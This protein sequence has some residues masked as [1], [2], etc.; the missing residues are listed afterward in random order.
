MIKRTIHTA[1]AIILTLCITSGTA[2]GKWF[3]SGTPTDLE[4]PQMR[5]LAIG[6]ENGLKTLDILDENHQSVG[7]LSLRQFAFSKTFTC[8]IVEGQL[9]FGVPDGM[10][11]D[12]NPH[13]KLVASFDW[14]ESTQ[15]V[16]LLFLPRSLNIDG[17]QSTADYTIQLID[18]S[19][20]S[21][22]LGHTQV[23]NLTSFNAIVRVEEHSATVAPWDRT[24]FS[25][26]EEST[27]VN[28]AQ[29]EV[30]YLED[31]TE[32][33]AYQARIRYLDRIRYIAFIYTDTKRERIAVR[34][35]KD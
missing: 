2:H 10:D 28:M 20:E 16:C 25:K 6:L 15:Q 12:G 29:F 34:I 4:S 27:G 24:Q 7:K 3:G 23:I 11:D 26:I 17:A 18:M 5:A 9:R 35:V 31:G 21:F 13:F 8:P 30:S 19:A 14:K 33:N 22:E 32:H 1:L